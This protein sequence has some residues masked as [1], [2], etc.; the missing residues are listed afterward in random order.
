MKILI[1]S[2]PSSSPCP[3]QAVLP[4]LC[5]LIVQHPQS[6]LWARLVAVVVGGHSDQKNPE[7]N[8]LVIE[9]KP[10]P[11]LQLWV[12]HH[13]KCWAMTLRELRSSCRTLPTCWG[14]FALRVLFISKTAKSIHTHTYQSIPHKCFYFL[15]CWITHESE[16]TGTISRPRSDI[17]SNVSPTSELVVKH[18]WT[19]PTW[20]NPFEILGKNIQDVLS[21]NTQTIKS[22]A[23]ILI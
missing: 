10:T 5:C 2:F 15:T 21:M 19:L 13:E 3:V 20:S 22:K 17:F 4:L 18:V 11:H 9:K 14:N 7:K 12:S 23:F 16:Y 8:T 6:T 1:P